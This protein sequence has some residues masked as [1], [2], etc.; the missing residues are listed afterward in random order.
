MPRIATS[1]STV[2]LPSRSRKPHSTGISEPSERARSTLP[3]ATGVMAMSSTIGGWARRGNVHTIGLLPNSFRRL[4]NG[5]RFG[6][7]VVVP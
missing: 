2:G 7:D 5:A 6:T 3:S 4:P 1:G